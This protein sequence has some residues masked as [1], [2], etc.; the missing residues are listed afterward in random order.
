ML[1]CDPQHH[2]PFHFIKRF[3]NTR[4]PKSVRQILNPKVDQYLHDEILCRGMCSSAVEIWIHDPEVV[5]LN[6]VWAVCC[7][8]EQCTFNL[9][10]TILS[11]FLAP[12]EMG[13]GV[14]YLRDLAI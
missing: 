4:G 1:N 5:S 14:I 12:L 6:P 7:V 8:L 11:I 2:P 10:P 13:A 9:L 3:L